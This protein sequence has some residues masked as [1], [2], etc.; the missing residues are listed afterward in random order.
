MF[1]K[2]NFLLV[3]LLIIVSI[4]AVSAASDIDD[5][6]GD[7]AISDIPI[8][9]SQNVESDIDAV[10]EDD[11]SDGNEILSS[12]ASDGEVI[13]STSHNVSASNY[14]SYFNSKGEL[15]SSSVNDGDTIYLDGEFTNRNFVFKKPVNV[16]GTSSNVL[17][18]STVTFYKGASG[19]TVSNLNIFNNV[20][21]QYGIFL[22]GATNCVVSGCFINNTGASSY[23]ICLGNNANYNNITNN[24]FNAYGIT[25]GHGTRSTS[26]VLITGSHYNYIA[27]NMISCDDAN[28]IYLSSYAGGPLDGGE[29]TYNTIYNNTIKYNVLPTSWAYGIQVMGKKNTL[30]SNTIIGAYRGIST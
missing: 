14:G 9:D 10:S 12:D 1:K 27:S 17:R 26:P 3:L 4:G 29:S 30:D 23:A 7:E 20:E 16:V 25:Y 28:A 15:I 8:L 24:N 6:I 5:A 13:A 2:I 19:S 22:N 21:Y 18:G 11:T